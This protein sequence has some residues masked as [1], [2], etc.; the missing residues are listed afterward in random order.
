MDPKTAA[1]AGRQQV[2]Y[3]DDRSAVAWLGWLCRGLPALCRVFPTQTR[4][5]ELLAESLRE[6]GLEGYGLTPASCSQHLRFHTLF[7]TRG[8]MP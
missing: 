8:F 3:V 2:A 6:L 4:F 7:H 1:F 5:D